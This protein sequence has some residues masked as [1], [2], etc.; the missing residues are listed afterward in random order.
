[1]KNRESI[2]E[3]LKLFEGDDLLPPKPLNA[4]QRV[5][6]VLAI[7]GGRPVLDY[8]ENKNKFIVGGDTQECQLRS[9]GVVLLDGDDYHLIIRYLRHFLNG[10]RGA[11]KKDED[12]QLNKALSDRAIFELVKEKLGRAGIKARTTRAYEILERK[13]NLTN[14]QVRNRI[15]AARKNPFISSIPSEVITNITNAIMLA[16][17]KS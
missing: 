16:E 17:E 1:V 8:S 6:T 4:R 5:H 10:K 14:K 12:E 9:K 3:L 11:P 2:E 13:W 15:S 7:L